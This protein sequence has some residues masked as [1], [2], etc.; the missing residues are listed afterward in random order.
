MNWQDGE[1]VTPLILASFKNHPDLVRLFLDRGADKSLRDKWDRQALT[2]ALR[3]GP[4]DPIA[5]MLRSE[6]EAKAAGDRFTPSYGRKI[7]AF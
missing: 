5:G 7:S 6:Y 2:Y 1:G 3:R 4:D